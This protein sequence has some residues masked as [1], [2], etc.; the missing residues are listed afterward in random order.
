M[1]RIN[2]L[3]ATL[4]IATITGAGL[5][6]AAAPMQQPQNGNIVLMPMDDVVLAAVMQYRAIRDAAAAEVNNAPEAQ[7]LLANLI[8]L[9]LAFIAGH[10][11]P[12]YVDAVAAALAAEQALHQ[13]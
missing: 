12:A 2:L 4:T 9:L 10:Y 6:A 13:N 1:K 5:H 7:A 3:V 8:P 11:P